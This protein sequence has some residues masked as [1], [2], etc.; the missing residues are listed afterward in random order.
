MK[1]A[2]GTMFLSGVSVIYQISAYHERS[3]NY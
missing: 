1:Q 3:Q 2:I